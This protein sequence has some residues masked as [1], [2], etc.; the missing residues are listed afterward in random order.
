M[1]SNKHLKAA[2]QVKSQ[3]TVSAVVL[4]RA[5]T[6]SRKQ[7]VHKAEL[8]HSFHTAEHNI[9][10]NASTHTSDLYSHLF[11]DS[12]I[13]KEF[14]C[15]RSKTG[16]LIRQVLGPHYQE[17]VVN[18][19]KSNY[20]SLMFDESTDQGVVTH[21]ACLVKI[22]DVNN[23]M[24]DY[25]LV[26][27]RVKSG[28]AVDLFELLDKVLSEH[29]VSW[30][31]CLGWNSDNCNAMFG[32]RNSVTS[33]I[34]QKQPNVFLQGCLCHLAALI[35][36][37]ASKHFPKVVEQLLMDVHAY[38]CQSSKRLLE[39]ESFQVF[40]NTEPHKLLKLGQTRW[41]SLQQCVAQWRRFESLSGGANL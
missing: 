5:N 24:C 4:A 36:S 2:K 9:A 3:P 19:I 16:A 27:E 14:K 18:L 17:M 6:E 35:A 11:S 38:F 8:I 22:W 26:M 21:A 15:K 34:K 25:Y 37:K 29:G 20:F 12:K 39:Y 7:A 10:F 13:A 1:R 23:Q 32:Q 33:R 41:L 28:K 31:Y 30:K 40:T